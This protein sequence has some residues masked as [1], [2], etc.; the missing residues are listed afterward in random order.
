[1]HAAVAGRYGERS[2]GAVREQ[3]NGLDPMTL[4]ARPFCMDW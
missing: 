3:G 4:M 2:P 1:L